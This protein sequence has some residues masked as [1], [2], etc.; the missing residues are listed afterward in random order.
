MPK[1]R[2]PINECEFETEDEASIVAALLNLHATTHSAQKTQ[3][4]T[5]QVEK[6]KRPTITSA[7]STEEWTYSES[8]WTDYKAATK[9]FGQD[10]IFQLLECCDDPLRKDLTRTSPNLTGK[11][12]QDILNAIK[13][14]CHDRQSKKARQHE[15]RQRRTSKKL[16][17]SPAFV[18]K[19]QSAK[20]QIPSPQTPSAHIERGAF[21]SSPHPIRCKPHVLTA[22][23]QDTAKVLHWESNNVPVLLSIRLATTAW[24]YTILN[25]F[26]EA[27]HRQKW[28]NHH[29]NLMTWRTLCPIHYAQF[30]RIH[31][32]EWLWTT[33][34]MCQRWEKR[35]S[36]PQ[37]FFDIM[38]D[39][40][41]SDFAKLGFKKNFKPQQ[42]W[43]RPITNGYISLA[44]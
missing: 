14:K 19:R 29:R 4:P 13:G 22:E 43:L 15:T 6:V 31:P 16:W 42:Q 7:S 3:Q 32:T 28:S 18:A 27:K 2:C 30:T 5:T 12:E 20:R 35:K 34:N 17:S 23:K 8:R 37:L 41:P 11:S 39:I 33:T 40:L 26:V 38:I 24:N 36:D 44:P 9:I 21:K 1:I 10:I 25:Q